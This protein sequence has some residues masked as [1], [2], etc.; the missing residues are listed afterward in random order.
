MTESVPTKRIIAQE[1]QAKRFRTSLN[2]FKQNVDAIETKISFQK[3]NFLELSEHSLLQI[4]QDTKNLKS[5]LNSISSANSEFFESATKF[6]TKSLDS[7]K[8][9]LPINKLAEEL[10]KKYDVEYSHRMSLQNK[11]NKIQSEI[12]ETT[13]NFEKI[14]SQTGERKATL[15]AE[16]KR[17]SR[18]KESQ[19]KELKRE[20]ETG[21][22]IIEFY[23]TLSAVEISEE[24][25][26]KFKVKVRWMQ[27]EF[28]FLL[29]EEDDTFWYELIG[30]TVHYDKIPELLKTEINI[31]KKDAPILLNRILNVLN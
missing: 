19:E 27:E 6:T 17:L 5:A 16:L 15:R 29:I 25:Q 14:K 1:A 8:E 12:Y 13:Q 31:D 23:K 28:S 20:I 2:S 30:C 7:Y 11:I 9:S 24:G 21:Q 3:I 18:D 26:G 4:V 10:Q 22:K